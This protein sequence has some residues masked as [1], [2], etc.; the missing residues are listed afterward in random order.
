MWGDSIDCARSTASPSVYDGRE[1]ANGAVVGKAH[2]SLEAVTISEFEAELLHCQIGAP[3]ML[4]RHLAVD[5]AGRSV[6]HG[7]DSYRDERA[8]F[9]ADSATLAQDI[10]NRE[11]H[12]PRG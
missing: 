12:F 10:P 1:H 11:D 8:R 9:I 2:L 6:D 7:C 3:A 4:E 5:T